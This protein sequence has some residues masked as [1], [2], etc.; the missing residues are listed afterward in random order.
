M[1]TL[2]SQN[3]A[4]NHLVLIYPSAEERKHLDSHGPKEQKPFS[5]LDAAIAC[6]IAILEAQQDPFAVRIAPD[7]EACSMEDYL[8]SLNTPGLWLAGKPELL[9][10]GNFIGILAEADHWR[11][12]YGC[13]TAKDIADDLD[14]CHQREMRKSACYWDWDR[15]SDFSD[16]DYEDSEFSDGD[17]LPCDVKEY[18]GPHKDE[19]CGH[20]LDAETCHHGCF[21]GAS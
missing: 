4:A 5:D 1:E 19:R 20:R 14:A 18:P 16:D 10:A 12:F 7:V 6:A 2:I 13:S 21:F 9:A 17:F 15:E 3:P 8:R 11:N